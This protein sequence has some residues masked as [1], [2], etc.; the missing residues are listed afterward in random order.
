MTASRRP[1]PH[2]EYEELAAGHALG[3]LEP[4]DEQRFLEHLP[5]CARCERDRSAYADTAAQLAYAAEP[6]ELPDG[7]LDRLREQVRAEARPP[8]VP[9]QAAPVGDV[10]AARERR[11]LRGLPRDRSSLTAAAAA[12]VVLVGLVGWNASLQ[13]DN[14]QMDQ[15]GDELAQAVRALTDEPSRSVPLLGEGNQVAAVAVLA[16]DHVSLVVNALKANDAADT[17]Y[18]LWE[19]GRYGDVRAVGTFDV[20]DGHLEVVRDLPLHGRAGDVAVLAVTHEQG[21]AAPGRPTQDPVAAGTVE[22]A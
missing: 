5:G 8:V 7:M 18:V 14:Q 22:T 3:A 20:R 1:D 19:K 12:L 9:P 6:L 17:T 4:E 2:K 11:R 13:R 10:A 15:R 16:E 21:N